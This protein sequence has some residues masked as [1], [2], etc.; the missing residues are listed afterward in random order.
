M[1]VPDCKEWK[2]TCDLEMGTLERMKCWEIVD[3]STMPPDSELL[4]LIFAD[5]FASY[6]E[7][8]FGSNCNGWF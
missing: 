5:S 4:Q 1:I 2:Y 8:Y 3:E 6:I 7:S